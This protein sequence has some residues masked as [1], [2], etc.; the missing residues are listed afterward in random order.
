MS[1]VAVRVAV[2]T[3]PGIQTDPLL[4]DSHTMTTTDHP[5]SATTWRDLADQ[6]T[7]KQ[8]LELEYCEREQIPPGLATP[9]HLCTDKQTPARNVG[10]SVIQAGYH[11]RFETGRRRKVL[12]EDC[13]RWL[14]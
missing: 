2:H 14:R 8:I 3:H 1:A 10:G 13:F 9:Q 4:N 5:D 6:L 11:N 7:P 12:S